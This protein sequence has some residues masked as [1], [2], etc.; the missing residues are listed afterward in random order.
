[1]KTIFRGPSG[2]KLRSG[3]NRLTGWAASGPA[4]RS[5]TLSIL[6]AAACVIEI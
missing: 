4:F 2:C 3:T 6:S 5:R 1:M